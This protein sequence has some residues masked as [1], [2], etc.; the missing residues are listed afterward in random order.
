MPEEGLEITPDM[1]STSYIG[2][3]QYALR[4]PRMKSLLK[5]MNKEG[6]KLLVDPTLAVQHDNKIVFGSYRSWAKTIRILPKTHWETF[7][8]EHQHMIFDKMGF[9]DVGPLYRLNSLEQVP[10]EARSLAKKVYALKK[11]GLNNLAI[12]ETLAVSQEI[13]SLYFMGYAP[14]TRPVYRAREY[15]W[16][17]QL[18]GFIGTPSQLKSLQTKI[19]LKRFFLNPYVVRTVLGLSGFLYIL[20]KEDEDKVIV[21]DE[22]GVVTHHQVLKYEG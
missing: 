14:W 1:L 12:D 6:Y 20:V 5:K 2:F 11:H 19:A 13:K 18:D 22:Q 16:Q 21:I 10:P 4:H 7:M 8:H 9:G 15:A 17:H 3:T